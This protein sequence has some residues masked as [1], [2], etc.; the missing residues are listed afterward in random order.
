MG[1]FDTILVPCPECGQEEQF[2]SKGGDCLLEVVKLRDCPIDILSD[3]NRHAPYLC[4]CGTQF[5]VD[6]E[7][8]ESVRHFC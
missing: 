7:N 5:K 8:K 4:D 6:L 2:Q 3:A 1:C